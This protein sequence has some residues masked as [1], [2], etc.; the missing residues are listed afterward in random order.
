MWSAVGVCVGEEVKNGDW[1]VTGAGFQL[2]KVKDFR[3]WM[4]VT[5]AQRCEC[6]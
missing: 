5:V 6:S 2:E 1:Y 3:R 4:V